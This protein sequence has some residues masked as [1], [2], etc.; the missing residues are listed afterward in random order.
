[1]FM[2]TSLHQTWI[3]RTVKTETSGWEQKRRR[4]MPPAFCARAGVSGPASGPR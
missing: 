2:F 4:D 1:M 3:G